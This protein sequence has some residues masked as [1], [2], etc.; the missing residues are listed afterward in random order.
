[1]IAAGGIVIGVAGGFIL[2]RLVGSY[3]TAVRLPGV[4]PLVGAALLLVAA[5]ILASLV[6]AARAARV[7]VLEAL[8]SD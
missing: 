4:L 8:R 7:N 1:V 6:P 5:A 2:A 3:V